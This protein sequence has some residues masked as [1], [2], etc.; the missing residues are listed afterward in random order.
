MDSPRLV[1]TLRNDS[2]NPND[3]AAR[4]DSTLGIIIDEYSEPGHKFVKY[5][6]I[7]ADTSYSRETAYTKPVKFDKSPF[8]GTYTARDYKGLYYYIVNRDGR[9]GYAY[10]FKNV[11]KSDAS[12]IS[13]AH[14]CVRLFPVDPCVDGRLYIKV[15]S[16]DE[17]IKYKAGKSFH[18]FSFVMSTW[19][20]P[21]TNNSGGLNSSRVPFSDSMLRKGRIETSNYMLE[22]NSD[23][24]S[25]NFFPPHSISTK[26]GS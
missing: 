12:P 23:V 4:W 7:G 25:S 5:E 3:V 6:H 17:V 24:H 16:P 15:V 9:K 21:H 1:T 22:E 19:F 2:W 14:T 18:I 20:H 13:W 10:R 11:I 26:K 8:K